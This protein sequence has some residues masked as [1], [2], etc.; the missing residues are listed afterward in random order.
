MLMRVIAVIH[1]PGNDDAVDF[2]VGLPTLKMRQAKR[3]Q[4]AR[5]RRTDSRDFYLYL[6]IGLIKLL[7]HLFADSYGFQATVVRHTSDRLEVFLV[8]GARDRA[9]EYFCSHLVVVIKP[10][11]ALC[12][13]RNK[14]ER[15]GNLSVPFSSERGF[16][17]RGRALHWCAG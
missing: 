11:P 4:A 17:M 2:E 8:A 12:N 15:E 9:A 6:H 3:Q 10:K 16:R 13:S 7:Q 1:S 14:Q 5:L